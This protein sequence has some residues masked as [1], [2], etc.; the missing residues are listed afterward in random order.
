MPA[1]PRGDVTLTISSPQSWYQPGKAPR[2][3]VHAVSSA[4]RPCRFNMGTKFVSVVITSGNRRLW[5]SADCAS[6]ARSDPT[7]LSSGTS[8]VL[9]ISWDRRTSS[10]GCDS[11]QRLVRPGE[12]KVEAVA[13]PL[14]SGTVNVVLGAKGTSGP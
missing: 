6:G 13:G 9:R 2:F 14:H 4:S 5:S 1:C 8:A 3:K 11:A 12:Y 7:V 10:P